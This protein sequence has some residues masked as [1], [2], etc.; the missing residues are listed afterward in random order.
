MLESDHKNLALQGIQRIQLVVIIMLVACLF[1]VTAIAWRIFID[2]CKK[3][4]Q[5]D[6][7]TQY[8]WFATFVHGCEGI[9]AASLLYTLKNRKKPVERRNSGSI[10]ASITT[11]ETST[12]KYIANDAAEKA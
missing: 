9:V 6:Q 1:L 7:N 12:N 10:S 5:I 2:T 3:P 4:D 8:L 11:P